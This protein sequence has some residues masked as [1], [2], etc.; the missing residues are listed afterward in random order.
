MIITERTKMKPI[1]NYSKYSASEDGKVYSHGLRSGWLKPPVSK[2]GYIRYRIIDDNGK[3]RSVYAHQ[4]IALTFLPNP[5]N[6]KFVN[7]KD[8]DKSNNALNNLEWCTHSENIRHDWEMGTRS[9][10]IGEV[11]PNHIVDANKVTELRNLHSTGTLQKDLAKMF[12][13]SQATISQIIL[14]KTWRHI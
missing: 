14:R 9:R 12:G 2:N 3:K 6:K 1:P 7:H 13:I 10:L 11:N 5:D 8:H 4:L